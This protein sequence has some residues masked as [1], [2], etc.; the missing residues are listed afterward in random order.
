MRS[1]GA[2]QGVV[3]DSSVLINLAVADCLPL[4]AKF[5]NLEFHVPQEV[6][7]EIV[8]PDQRSRVEQALQGRA[9]HEVVLDDLTALRFYA[10][11]RQTLG[12]GESA[13]LALAATRSW[14]VA[15]DE[16]RAF[17][18]E[19]TARLGPGRVLDTPGLLLLAVR[20]GLL[21]VGEADQVKELLER[22]R[23][24]M[25]FASFSEIV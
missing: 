13:C 23:F 17:L 5:E 8:R 25:T 18:R 20:R 12:Q 11:L 2:A 7:A 22:H 16:K 24:R 14:L 4:L 9:L 15:C 6:L 10:D 21:T 3:T 1:G 19:A